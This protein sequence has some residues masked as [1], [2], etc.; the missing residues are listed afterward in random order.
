[1][2]KFKLSA[3]KKRKKTKLRKTDKRENEDKKHNLTQIF[4][5]ISSPLAIFEIPG[6]MKIISLSYKYESIMN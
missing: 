3:I 4:Q 6:S 5:F 1:M 2:N